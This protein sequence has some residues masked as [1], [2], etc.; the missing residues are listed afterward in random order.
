VLIQLLHRQIRRR[1]H[2]FGF[3]D[4]FL[5]VGRFTL[6]SYERYCPDSRGTLVLLHGLGTSSSTWVRILPSLELKSNIVAL[7]LPGFGLSTINAG[8]RFADIHELQESIVEF[9]R[10][11]VPGPIILL[12]H[13]LG[14]WLAA[15]YAVEHAEN[16]NHLVLADSAGILCEETMEQ[17]NAFQ[18]ESVGDLIRLLDVIWFRYPWYF[19]PF[20][21]AVL[22]DMRK[23]QVAEFVRSIHADDF[24]NDI[25]G[26]LTMS[27]SIIW[28][29][30]DKLISMKSVDIM[31]QSLPNA[32]V[33]L[34]DQCGHVPQLEQPKNFAGIIRQAL[35][36]EMDAKSAQ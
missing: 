36:E 24:L 22:N 34:I 10:Q 32:R 13:S 21:P 15:K 26:K 3:E 28:G 17:G 18:V 14:G 20:Y 12:G 6:H 19:K 25:L 31:K 2:R 23:R 35:E 4:R 16:I 7:D 29:K 1:Y 33:Y 9:I 30:E 5:Q 11:R 27:V 8:S